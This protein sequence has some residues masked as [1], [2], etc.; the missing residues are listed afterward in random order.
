V[1]GWRWLFSRNDVAELLSRIESKIIYPSNQTESLL[2]LKTA[3]PRLNCQLTIGN[4]VRA[5]LEDKIAPCGKVKGLGLHQ[6]LFSESALRAHI[7]SVQ[8]LVDEDQFTVHEVAK[9]FRVRAENVYVCIK[10]GLLSAQKAPKGRMSIYCV[11]K[12]AIDQFESIYVFAAKIENFGTSPRAM[13]ALLK[14]HGIHPISGPNAKKNSAFIFKRAELQPLNLRELLRQKRAK[15]DP[16]GTHY[17]S[18][19]AEKVSE[20]L[21]IDMPALRAL[22]SAKEL[23]PICEIP[24]EDGGKPSYRFSQKDFRRYTLKLEKALGTRIVL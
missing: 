2:T 24:A 4:I 18:I 19:S 11:T 1:N 3:I 7:S 6:F 14:D 20:L 23:T 22:V 16:R 12:D 21:G 15:V 13:V 8:P 10:K 17:Q 5:I 9:L